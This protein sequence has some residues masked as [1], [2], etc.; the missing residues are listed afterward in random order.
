MSDDLLIKYEEVKNE[1]G[2]LHCEVGP[3]YI[4]WIKENDCIWKAFELYYQNGFR[5]RIGAPADISWYKDGSKRSELWQVDGNYHRL[6]G[7]C[8]S[9]WDRDGFLTEVDYYR[10][11]KRFQTTNTPAVSYFFKTPPYRKD[12]W[13][14]GGVKCSEHMLEWIYKQGYTNPLTVEQQVH[15]LLVWK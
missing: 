2:Q 7:P 10:F 14:Y 9:A 8:Y 5:H 11:G 15:F 6:D 3:A 4:K 12:I 1:K 13:V